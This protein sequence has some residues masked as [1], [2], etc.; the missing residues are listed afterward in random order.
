MTAAVFRLCAAGFARSDELLEAARP[1]VARELL[2]AVGFL[3]DISGL[4]DAAR[5]AMHCAALPPYP[6]DVSRLPGLQRAAR[7]ASSMLRRRL[8]VSE[9][10]EPGALCHGILQL[11]SRWRA[12]ARRLEEL[13]AQ[14][15]KVLQRLQELGV[16]AS[17]NASAPTGASRPRRR[18]EPPTPYE[19]Y[20]LE[21][22]ALLAE[23]MGDLER[24]MV[25]LQTYKE[26]DLFWRWMGSV[27]QVTS[28]NSPPSESW[29]WGYQMSGTEVAESLAEFEDALRALQAVQGQAADATQSSSLLSLRERWDDLHG[30]LGP[31]LRELKPKLRDMAAPLM[32][33]C[34]H[35]GL[36]GKVHA[37]MS[38]LREGKK[39]RHTLKSYVH[40]S[41]LYRTSCSGWTGVLGKRT[42][43]QSLRQI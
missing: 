19:L 31:E 40:S 18:I 14:R 2:L 6:P 28:P 7:E 33:C 23:H 9:D 12:E 37:E 36:S 24:Y 35:P 10:V 17:G 34:H 22:R 41:S 21:R 3:L 43:G 5:R 38:R 13:E 16:Q 26:D 8:Q 4:L 27:L 39:D 32:K 1:D 29:T 42:H 15:I 11:Q 25:R 30:K 20:V